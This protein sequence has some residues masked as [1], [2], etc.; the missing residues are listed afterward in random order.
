[1]F[2]YISHG[3]ARVTTDGSHTEPR[4]LQPAALRAH[5]GDNRAVLSRQLRGVRRRAEADRTGHGVQVLAQRHLARIHSHRCRA[6]SPEGAGRLRSPQ[7]RS[8]AHRAGEADQDPRPRRLE[9]SD[10]PSEY[11]EVEHGE[12]LA[13]PHRRAPCRVRAGRGKDQR[14]R[15]CCF[16]WSGRG[17]LTGVSVRSTAISLMAR[18]SKLPGA[19]LTDT[20]LLRISEEPLILTGGGRPLVPYRLGAGT[21][22]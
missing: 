13:R 6:S 4:W 5:G 3:D 21:P 18:Q 19:A 15:Y 22:R 9:W 7:A 1:M 10:G 2:S 17:A 14:V 12:Y 8:R 16:F 11:S 20:V